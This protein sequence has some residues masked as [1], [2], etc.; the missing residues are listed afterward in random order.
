M[1]NLPY[2][3]DDARLQPEIARYEPAQALFAGTDGLDSYRALLADVARVAP[4]WIALEHGDGQ[5][6][7]L[8]ALVSAAGFERVRIEPELGGAPRIVVGER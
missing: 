4:R 7:A 6:D 8:A 1:A 2:V 5:G 3:E